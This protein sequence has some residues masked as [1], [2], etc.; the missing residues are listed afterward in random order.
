[1]V[2][3]VYLKGKGPVDLSFHKNDIVMESSDGPLKIPFDE[4]REINL[5]PVRR[6]SHYYFPP[7]CIIK[8]IKKKYGITARKWVYR[9][10]SSMFES[11]SEDVERM[12]NFVHQFHGILVEKGLKE[13]I[14]FAFGGSLFKAILIVYPIFLALPVIDGFE[15]SPTVI[16]IVSAA[17]VLLLWLVKKRNYDPIRVAEDIKEASFYLS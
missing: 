16:F 14:R 8:T 13:K 6:T 15:G 12:S 5:I 11:S 10:V 2:H 17:Y 1:M 3:N 7:S 9:A 4:I